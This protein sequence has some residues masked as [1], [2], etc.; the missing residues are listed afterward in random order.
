MSIKSKIPL[1]YVNI[2]H[3]WCHIVETKECRRNFIWYNNEI[4]VDRQPFLCKELYNIGIMYVNDIFDKEGRVL[5]FEAIV[6][7]GLSRSKWLQWQG[8]VKAVKNFCKSANVNSPSH[9]KDDMNYYVL[10]KNVHKCTSKHIYYV[11]SK[12]NEMYVGRAANYVKDSLHNVSLDWE[13]IYTRP[14]RLIQDVRTREFQFRFLHDIL[15]NKYWLNKWKIVTNNACR[16]C[17]QGTEDILHIFWE[18]EAAKKFWGQFIQQM[19]RKTGNANLDVI[20][21]FFGNESELTCSLVF[22]AKKYL[23]KCIY[24]EQLPI[25]SMYWNEVMYVKQIEKEIAYKSNKLDRWRKK[26]MPFL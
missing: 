10:G 26:W 5:S 18:C 8:L 13:E 3:D 4:K 1:F 12:S 17:Q 25:F 24:K 19:E 7:M 20:D 22:K 23:Y 14:K 21:V 15:I 16:W 2:L 6:K 9:G 11:A